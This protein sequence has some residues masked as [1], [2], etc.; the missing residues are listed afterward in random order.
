MFTSGQIFAATLY[1]RNVSN[2]P[3]DIKRREETPRRSR[4]SRG[5][6][7][8]QVDNTQHLVCPSRARYEPFRLV[9]AVIWPTTTDLNS[10][11][12]SYKKRFRSCSSSYLHRGKVPRLE[13]GWLE[14]KKGRAG[15]PPLPPLIPFD[16]RNESLEINSI[17]RQIYRIRR[18]YSSVLVSL[19]IFANWGR[20][21]MKL[22]LYEILDRIVER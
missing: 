2:H 10:R 3:S 22:F 8:Y 21:E 4:G 20:G 1:E 16:S 19:E 13:I 5:K 14:G 15:R 17:V 9:Y 11:T 7:Y 6:R 12:R 18:E